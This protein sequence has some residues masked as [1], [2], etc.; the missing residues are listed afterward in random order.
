MEKTL[1]DLKKI[2]DDIKEINDSIKPQLDKITKLQESYD[3]VMNEIIDN[4]EFKPDRFMEAKG[5]KGDSYREGGLKIIRHK[6]MDRKLNQT[7]FKK[8]YPKEFEKYG[9]IGLTK[10]DK[11][12]GQDKTNELCVISEKVR[13]EFY[14]PSDVREE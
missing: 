5:I 3:D 7:K 14:D 13:F 12:I 6:R 1:N 4:V 9:E 11:A 2:K 10:A 8:L